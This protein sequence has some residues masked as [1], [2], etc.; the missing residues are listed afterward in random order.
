MPV[1]LKTKSKK[2]EELARKKR[3]KA[4]KGGTL[5]GQV[6]RTKVSDKYTGSVKK[7]KK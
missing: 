1:Q 5:A 6:L 7:M 3:I 2:R 4:K